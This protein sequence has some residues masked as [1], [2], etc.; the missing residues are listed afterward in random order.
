MSYSLI[1]KRIV[2]AK[3]RRP[4]IWCG[5]TIATGDRY[6]YEFSKFY[7]NIQRHHWHP[8]CDTAAAEYFAS[9]EGPEF[10]P[11][12]NERPK[13]EITAPTEAQKG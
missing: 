5:E 12:E 8:E 4:C 11:Y 6:V 1:S 9:D 13:A 2:V 3:K 10:S 7:G